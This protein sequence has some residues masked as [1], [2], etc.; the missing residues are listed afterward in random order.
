[1]ADSLHAM[2]HN[3]PNILKTVYDEDRV[4]LEDSYVDEMNHL[5]MHE[6]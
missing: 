4:R 3:L 6:Q 5:K 2:S 1:M